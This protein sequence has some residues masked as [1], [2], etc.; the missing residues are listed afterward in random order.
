MTHTAPSLRQHSDIGNVHKKHNG[1]AVRLCT[2]TK[3][4]LPD[5]LY[6]PHSLFVNV[7]TCFIPDIKRP[8]RDADSLSLFLFSTNAKISGFISIFSFIRR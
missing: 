6:D 5:K 3:E 2:K 4:K 8:E 7:Y 1:P